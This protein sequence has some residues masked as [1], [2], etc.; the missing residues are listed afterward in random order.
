MAWSDLYSPFELNYWTY[1]DGSVAVT[2]IKGE[3]T[4]IKLLENMD[5]YHDYLENLCKRRGMSK[6][7]K[8]IA[9]EGEILCGI[10]PL[11]KNETPPDR[12]ITLVHSESCWEV[13][14]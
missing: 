9:A 10:R 5:A 8:E 3:K 7:Q 11:F 13:F 4:E 1:D 14:S 12:R 6:F 2:F